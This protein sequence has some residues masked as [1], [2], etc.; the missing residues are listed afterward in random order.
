MDRGCMGVGQNC[1]DI[2]VPFGLTKL[3]KG[4]TQSGT[5]GVVIGLYYEVISNVIIFVIWGIVLQNGK[6][7]VASCMSL[8]DRLQETDD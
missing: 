3:L 4:G 7:V 1:R 2:I 5:I 8:V 6:R